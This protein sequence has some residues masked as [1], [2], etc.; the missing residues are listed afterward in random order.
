[1]S[2]LSELPISFATNVRAVFGDRG[3]VWLSRLD[4]IVDECVDRW[5]LTVGKPFDG[6]YVNFVAAASLADGTE[7]VLKIGVADEERMC[8]MA[9]LRVYGGSGAVRLIDSNEDGSCLLL[10]RVRPGTVLRAGDRDEAARVGGALMRRLWREPATDHPFPTVD[11]WMRG[12]DRMRDRFDGG[13][14]PI[15][16]R[17]VDIAEGLYSELST[18]ASPMLLHGDFHHDNVL[19]ATREPWLVIDPK[20][21]VGDPGFECGAFVVNAVGGVEPANLS[22]V[23]DRQIDILSETTGLTRERIRGWSMV[24]AVLSAWWGIEDGGECDGPLTGY[25][26]AL[27]LSVGTHP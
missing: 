23:I 5:S 4:A 26:Q 15:P 27:L 1:M 14:G 16:E 13:T 3:D 20:G 18:D 24:Q 11:D 10:E 6:S 25:V 17:L 9:A 8:E 12:F 22:R 19:S 7:A 2:N 21:V